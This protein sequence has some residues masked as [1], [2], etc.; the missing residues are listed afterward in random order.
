ML[1]IRRA[2]DGL[3]FNLSHADLR[4]RSARPRGDGTPTGCAPPG[5]PGR[6][7]AARGPPPGRLASAAPAGPCSA[8]FGSTPR[9]PAERGGTPRGAGKDVGAGSAPSS[10]ALPGAR[11]C[12]SSEVLWDTLSAVVRQS[13]LSVWPLCLPRAVSVGDV[14]SKKVPCHFLFVLSVGVGL[15]RGA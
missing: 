3:S 7:A 13:R 12:R 9:C 14:R 5:L 11:R 8:A 2:L 6:R 15:E 4:R 10:S 1:Q